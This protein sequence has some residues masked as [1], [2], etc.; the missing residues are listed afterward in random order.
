MTQ[1]EVQSYVHC[2]LSTFDLVSVDKLIPHIA[3][4]SNTGLLIKIYQISIH[5]FQ[6][7]KKET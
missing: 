3:D 6:K 1:Q 7:K 2:F 4:I 5:N